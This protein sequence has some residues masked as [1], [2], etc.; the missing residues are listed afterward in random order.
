[1]AKKKAADPGTPAPTTDISG[2]LKA[3]AKQ[4]RQLESQL[5]KASQSTMKSLVADFTK[6]LKANQL[7]VADAVVMLGG[8][9]GTPATPAKKKRTKRKPISRFLP[10]PSTTTRCCRS[11]SITSRN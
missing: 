6:S 9:A 3:L 11:L 7:T 2:Q 1:M 8:S 10:R 5:A 4:Q